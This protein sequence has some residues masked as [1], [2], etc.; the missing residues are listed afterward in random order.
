[1]LV[2]QIFID[3]DDRWIATAS[4][5]ICL[6][7][8]HKAWIHENLAPRPYPGTQSDIHEWERTNLCPLK[9]KCGPRR[10]TGNTD[11]H[12]KSSTV[13]FLLS[14]Y[15]LLIKQIKLTFKHNANN[16]TKPKFLISLYFHNNVIYFQTKWCTNLVVVHGPQTFCWFFPH[17]RIKTH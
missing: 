3:F 5:N 7:W 6:T 13:H 16:K 2:K 12:S 14:F 17:C 11:G 4:R 15:F 1:M 10:Q 9:P 8:T